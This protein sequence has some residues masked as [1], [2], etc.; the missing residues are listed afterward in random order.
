MMGSASRGWRDHLPALATL[1][2]V[3]G[4][5]AVAWILW[6]EPSSA[7]VGSPAP[8]IHG[9]GME[10]ETVTSTELDD[11]VVLLNIWATWCL[12]CR[13]EMPS[14]QRLY[15]RFHDEPF[16][17]VA[18]SVDGTFDTGGVRERIRSFGEELGLTFP[19][20]HDEAHVVRRR[21]RNRG[22]P[23]TFVIGRDGVIHRRVLGAVEWDDPEWVDLVETLL[24]PL[25]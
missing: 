12:P 17:V 23:E 6:D 19:L 22:V 14:I 15:E 5:L 3:A 10:G 4:G 9:V 1:A 2:V 18:V 21:Y 11:H 20:I 25:D 16:E 7:Q 13:E 24:A 8:A